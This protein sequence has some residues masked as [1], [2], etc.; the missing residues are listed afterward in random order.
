LV[1]MGR[2]RENAYCCGG[3][4]GGMWLDGFTSDYTSERL[5]ERRS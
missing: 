5:A 2:C 1:E 4:V 3:G